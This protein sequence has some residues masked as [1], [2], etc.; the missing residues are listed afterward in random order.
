MSSKVIIGLPEWNSSAPRV[1]AEKL[2]RGLNAL[3]RNTRILLTEI[4]PDHAPTGSADSVLPEDIAFD[5]LPAGR[6]DSRGVLWQALIRFL[7]E[8]APCIFITCGDWRNSVVAPRLSDRIRILCI[9]GEDSE[10]E[11]DQIQRLGHC[12]NAIVAV[13]DPIHFNAGCRF[14][15]LAPRMAT[16]PDG[17]DE[18]DGKPDPDML[19]SYL[20]L[21]ERIEAR[22]ERR[23][24]V[25][26]RGE[27]TAPPTS[28][29]GIEVSSLPALEAET[30]HVNAHPLWPNPPAPLKSKARS[31]NSSANP[32]PARLEDYRVA[33]AIPAGQISG[34]DTFACH[35]IRRLRRQGI[36][37][38]IVG[39]G[40]LN[41]AQGLAL[42][43]DIPVEGYPLPWN[44]PWPA[45]WDGMIGRLEDLAPCIYIPN[46]DYAHSGIC[47]RLSDR[48]KVINIAHSDDPAHYEHAARL[49]RYSNAVVG[50]SKAIVD[51]LAGLD[52]TLAPRLHYIPYGIELPPPTPRN[53][54]PDAPLRLIYVGRLAGYQK[55]IVDLIHIVKGLEARRIP[56]ELT[57]IGDGPERE[58][59]HKA[60]K[61]LI[62]QRKVW[63]PGKLNNAEV[64]E[65]L[66]V[67][68]ALLLPS[69]FE[70]LSVSMLEAMACGAIPVV[71]G[72]RSGVPELIRH[73]ENGMIAP[74]G[75]IE[76]FVSHLASL[77]ADPHK[78][79]CMSQAA[80]ETIC[81]EGYRVENMCERYIEL[82][83]EVIA[84]PYSRPAGP[85]L[86]PDYLRPQMA[87]QVQLPHQFRRGIYSA[88]HL[89]GRVK[90]KIFRR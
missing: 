30:V 1:R 26:P 20:T 24:F 11:Y 63:F 42:A 33:L 3:G 69:A 62:L 41:D 25:R 19:R 79:I 45:R 17:N 15:H 72:I 78:R 53:V 70:G 12:F 13:S 4:Q 50:V 74:V 76:G 6:Q 66:R 49:G 21:I 31:R 18:N 77:Y 35:L 29:G 57:I 64:A 54:A 88:R 83:R 58:A 85:I 89:L 60:G 61:S 37:A 16:I 55:R 5:Q 38:M 87:W 84:H 43:D 82:F 32:T 56:F 52:P 28:V 36:E 80:Y 46:Y 90:R 81:A 14:P 34:V 27:M 10:L 59:L 51:H 48:V 22:A 9:M 75:D 47:P 73:G 40:V 65:Q 2:A 86:P 7:E 8:N 23:E 67:H 44:A 39:G 68:D 71:S